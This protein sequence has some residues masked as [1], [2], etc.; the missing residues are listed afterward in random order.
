MEQKSAILK[1]IPYLEQ[2]GL[3]IRHEKNI[4]MV[5]STIV[6][7]FTLVQLRNIPGWMHFLF[8]EIIYKG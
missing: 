8:I 1:N 3:K 2:V 7:R 5:V 6:D 4:F